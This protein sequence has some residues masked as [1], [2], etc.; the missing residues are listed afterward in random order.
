MPDLS[1]FTQK[2]LHEVREVTSGERIVCVGWIEVILSRT[3][4]E[5]LSYIKIAIGH[6]DSIAKDKGIPNLT[7]PTKD[8]RNILEIDEFDLLKLVKYA[9]LKTTLLDL[10]YLNLKFLIR[11]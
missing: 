8:S 3:T 7:L 4:K 10:Y 5:M 1:L 9:E 11:S 6:I 2:Y